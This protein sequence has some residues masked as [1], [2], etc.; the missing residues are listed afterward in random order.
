MDRELARQLGEEVEAALQSVAAKHGMTVT[1][2]GG[3]FETT[4]LFK[5]RVEFRTG[6]VD[7]QQFLRYAAMFGLTPEH[8]GRTFVM[9]GLTYQI[10]GLKPSAPKRPVLAR[11]ADNGKIYVFPLDMVRALLKAMDDTGR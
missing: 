7:R 8:F 4:G 3:T 2:T 9:D 10:T 5:P 11:R 6:D 1:C